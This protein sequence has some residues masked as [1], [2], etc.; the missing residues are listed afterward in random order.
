MRS[1]I[2]AAGFFAAALGLSACDSSKT[3][4]AAAPAAPKYVG[5]SQQ[6]YQGQEMVTKVDTAAIKVGKDGALDM[7][8]TGSVPSAGYKNAG[9]LKRIYAGPP[10]DGIYEMDVVADAPNPPG[11]A[12]PTPIEVKGPWEK[13]PADRVKG[14]RF[15][16]KT[17]SVVA[18]LPAG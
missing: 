17:N 6:M 3:E 4:T 7:Q 14:V 12:A 16:S 1:V 11:A 5:R 2:L 8:A 9:F 15:I 18:M 13:Y 10:A